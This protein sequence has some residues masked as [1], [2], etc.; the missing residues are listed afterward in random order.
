MISFLKSL[1]ASLKRNPQAW[2]MWC[3]LIVF[4]LLT[5]S[6]CETPLVQRNVTQFRC[7]PILSKEY[8]ITFHDNAATRGPMDGVAFF[9]RKRTDL[10]SDR[11]SDG[12]SVDNLGGSS[13]PSIR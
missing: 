12:A 7:P 3:F 8:G 4:G 6:G 2:V 11:G 9:P 1:P 10:E 5:L 13:L